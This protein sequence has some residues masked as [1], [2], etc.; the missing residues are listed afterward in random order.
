[1]KDISLQLSSLFEA[2]QG[3]QVS[4]IVPMP[5]TGS[6]RQYFRIYDTTGRS[7]IGVFNNDKK[8]NES[9]LYFARHFHSHGLPVPE[10]LATDPNNN[11]YLQQDLG[12]TTLFSIVET[13]NDG[14]NFTSQL[15]EHYINVIKWLPA[16]QIK[17]ANTL[18]FSYCHPR[19]TFDHQSMLW[20]LNY[21]KYYFLKL[22][23][24]H[25][26]EEKLEN[27]FH[28]FMDYLSEAPNHYFMY[29]DFQ[30]RNIIIH[31][32]Q[33]WFIDF[34]GGRRGALQYDI[35][36]LLY[37]AKANIPRDLREK[38]LEIYLDELT[39]YFESLDCE[40]FR[41][42]FY[43]FVLIRLMQAMGAYGYRGF[44]EGK[45]HFLQSIPYAVD[46]L[47][48]ILD[49]HEIPVKIPE[50]EYALRAITHSK[51]LLTLAKTK[52]EL[53]INISSFSYQRGIPVDTSGHG[54]GFVFDCRALPNPGRHEIFE[55]L[56]GN[57]HKVIN[58][59]TDKPEMHKFLDNS[60]ALIRQSVENYL[61]RGFNQ[62][63]V[64]FG[65][66]G[67]QHRSVYCA[68]QITEKLKKEFDIRINLQH[69][70]LE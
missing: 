18:D 46:N 32:Q 13:D 17:T 66:T 58:F 3:E 14:Y 37:D 50:L 42:Y 23:G 56:S 52:E 59:F 69:L 4:Q 36:S 41:E 40:K 49:N 7:V 1:M 35:A 67:G 38:F 48:W 61:E 65:C 63:S 6:G 12:D 5:R 34:Q 28:V 57:D 19:K 24:I 21:F 11:I 64:N 31:N 30:S 47:S 27:D 22:G 51:K 62:L 33:P 10:I 68:N 43:A 16:F 15:K 2:T 60:Y 44:F 55:N 54:G 53:N 9:F 20:D 39:K 29:R 25:F 26:D 45:K 70:E 8:E